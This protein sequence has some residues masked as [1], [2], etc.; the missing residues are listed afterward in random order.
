MTIFV[1]SFPL[2]PLFAFFN[3]VFEM[4]LDGKKLLTHYR[5]PVSQRV[6][7]IGIWFKIL[8]FIG[9]LAVVTNVS[10][11]II[12]NS[13]FIFPLNAKSSFVEFL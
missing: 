3:N 5:R 4:R 2:A 1:S 11:N 6:K 8:D 9:K 12:I 7:D 10:I 13:K